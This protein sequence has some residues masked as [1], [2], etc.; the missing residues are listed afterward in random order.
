MGGFFVP[1]VD[2]WVASRLT[3]LDT[4]GYSED[5]LFVYRLPQDSPSMLLLL[6]ALAHADTGEDCLAPLTLRA[7][8]PDFDTTDVPTNTRITVSLIGGG[9]PEHVHMRLHGASGLIET[10]QQA[11]CY[12]HESDYERHCTV[13]LTPLSVLDPDTRH[14]VLLDPSD[15]HPEP[16]PEGLRS[17]FRTGSRTLVQT[18]DAPELQQLGMRPR[19][20]EDVELCEWSDAEQADFTVAAGELEGSGMATVEVM[21]TFDGGSGAS[22]HTLFLGADGGV[23]DFRQVLEPDDVRARC[24]AAI[25]VDATGA[26]SP[27]SEPVCIY[28]GT[29][30]ADP[31]DTAAGGGRADTGPTETVDT[32]SVDSADASAEADDSGHGASVTPQLPTIVAPPSDGC[33]KG[34]SAVLLWT[35]LF[36]VAGR[37][38]QSRAG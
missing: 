3:A 5:R 23:L 26:V 33:G 10:T 2:T 34:A 18:L 21:E 1:S 12:V 31:E 28:D 22:V 17:S 38:R 19:P 20:E 13:V 4:D 9:E 30:V 7:M 32:A 37:R 24:Y 11:W 6:W 29:P 25:V 35:W 14:T 36:G 15:S 27:P 16:I 8:R